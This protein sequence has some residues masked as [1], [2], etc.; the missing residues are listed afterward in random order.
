MI[1]PNCRAENP[2]DGRF[3]TSCGAALPAGPA[4][5]P[6][7]LPATLVP[8]PLVP[9][10]SPAERRQLTVMLC[11]LVGSTAL[12]VRLDPE[13]LREVLVAYQTYV[14]DTVTRF[15]GF[16]AG[17]MGDGVLVYF[18][19]PQAHEHDAERAARAGLELVRGLSVRDWPSGVVPQVRIGIATGLVVVGSL[20]GEDEAQQ[21]GIVG[22]TPNLAARLQT[23]AEPDTVVIDAVTHRLTGGLFDYRDLGAAALKGFDEAVPAWQ[24]V[25][26]S[27]QQSR[28]DALHAAGVAPLLALAFPLRRWGSPPLAVLV[29]TQAI[30][31]WLWHTPGLY[32]WGLAS[33]PA[34]WLMQGSLLGS[35]WLMWR[36][37]LAPPRAQSGSALVALVATVGQMGLLGARIVFASR[38]LYAVHFATTWPW[39]FSPL[40]DQQLAGLLMWVPALLPYLGVGL[41][42]AWSSLRPAEPIR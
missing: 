28:F 11:D 20:A 19:Y 5:S 40:A 16:V 39:G 27:A 21:H 42:L 22:G 18:G 36:A 8:P 38:P 13:D 14:A 25:G 37:I 32:A 34:Y 17:Y 26:E 2:D 10:A 15:G 41:W 35:G 24:V 31:L 6:A 3:C 1:C 7:I 12:S 30:I 9:P 23:L 4:P 33:V 29:V